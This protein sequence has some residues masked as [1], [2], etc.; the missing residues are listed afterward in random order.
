[1]IVDLYF[2]N[3]CI[4][5][6]DVACCRHFR[7]KSRFLRFVITNRLASS[8]TLAGRRV[9]LSRELRAPKIRTT[10]ALISVTHLGRLVVPHRSALRGPNDF[11]HLCECTWYFV[12]HDRASSWTAVCIT[13]LLKRQMWPVYAKL[14]TDRG[15]GEEGEQNGLTNLRL[16]RC[17][18][19][20]CSSSFSLPVLFVPVNFCIFLHVLRIGNCFCTA[21]R[22]I[23]LACT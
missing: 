18:S 6:D 4:F 13:S 5:V 10:A 17:R 21:R 20:C 19:V 23:A 1:M 14:L 2:N 12:K 9:Q 22:T 8:S 15:Q 16:R 3:G 7:Y 11:F